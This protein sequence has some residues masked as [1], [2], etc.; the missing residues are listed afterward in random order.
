VFWELDHK[1]AIKFWGGGLFVMYI[2]VNIHYHKLRAEKNDQ[3]ALLLTS[4]SLSI[5]I[6]GF[7]ENYFTSVVLECVIIMLS[8]GISLSKNFSCTF[9]KYISLHITYE[10][11]TPCL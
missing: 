3:A 1:Y 9:F 4:N 5:N 10:A 2:C 8:V 7:K 6:K 11:V